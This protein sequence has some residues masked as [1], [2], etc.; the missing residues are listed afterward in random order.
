MFPH[1]MPTTDPLRP[2][3]ATVGSTYASGELIYAGNHG[4]DGSKDVT[5][6]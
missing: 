1:C 2:T 4:D 5:F 6:N 3:Y